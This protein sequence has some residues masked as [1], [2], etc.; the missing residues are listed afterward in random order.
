M[1]SDLPKDGGELAALDREAMVLVQNPLRHYSTD[2]SVAAVTSS[3]TLGPIV[4]VR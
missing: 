1:K 2:S 3:A 4:V